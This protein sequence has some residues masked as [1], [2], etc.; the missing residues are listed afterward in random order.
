MLDFCGNLKYRIGMSTI[1]YKTDLL[2]DASRAL[3]YG[4]LHERLL[5]EI[6]LIDLRLNSL[7]KDHKWRKEYVSR[8]DS[9]ERMLKMVKNPGGIN[10]EK[11][12]YEFIMTRIECAEKS[13]CLMSA[14][15]AS[16]ERGNYHSI[17]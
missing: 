8:K 6:K 13:G 9:C 10:M 17:D 14:R 2:A 5:T 3:C 11:E 4:E 15:L 7:P 1:S 12:L 16:V